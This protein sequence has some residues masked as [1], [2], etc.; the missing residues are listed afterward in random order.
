MVGSDQIF[1]ETELLTRPKRHEEAVTNATTADWLHG[2]RAL[3][4]PRENRWP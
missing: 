4:P 3:P 2:S 1:V